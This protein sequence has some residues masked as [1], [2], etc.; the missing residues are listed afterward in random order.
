MAWVYVLPP[1][2]YRFKI[3]CWQDML[4]KC[5]QPD[6]CS[7]HSDSRRR[8]PFHGTKWKSNWHSHIRF[9]AIEILYWVV[10]SLPTWGQWN[11]NCIMQRF[12]IQLNENSFCGGL[13]IQIEQL[14]LQPKLHFRIARSC[15]HSQENAKIR[16][17]WNFKII[18]TYLKL[19][20]YH[21][22]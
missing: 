1:I 5:S 11:A 3:N 8:A 6:S 18:L 19:Y 12:W 16:T 14:Y 4:M 21:V 20:L 22:P 13:S 7:F 2:K 17:A 9:F 15:C 10:A